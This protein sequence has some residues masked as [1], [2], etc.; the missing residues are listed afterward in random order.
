[1]FYLTPA[2]LL[3][4]AF[5]L[6]CF[7]GDPQYPLHPVRIIGKAVTTLKNLLFE[8]KLNGF[9]SGLL[10]TVIMIL[11]TLNIYII[12]RSLLEILHPLAP[13]PLD[14]FLIYSSIALKD[15]VKHAM[16]IAESLDKNNLQEARANVDKI[17]GRD[18]SNLDKDN[19]ARAAVESVAENYVDGFFAP[20]FWF[21]A[22][23][24]LYRYTWLSPAVTGVMAILIY[25][26]INTMDAMIGHKNEEYR[27]FGTFA[28]RFDDV[29]N[30]IPARLSL[31]VLTPA[32]FICRLNVKQAVRT[33]FRDR[34]KHES[35]NSAHAESF[36]AG[37]LNLK[38]GGPTQYPYGTVEKPWLGDGTPDATPDQIRTACKLITLAGWIS[39]VICLIILS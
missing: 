15:M 14:I 17:V 22:A 35:P 23:T 2:T 34:L 10:L 18:C 11:V 5:S 31:I 4:L 6:D 33:F 36:V 16:P 9:F 8:M 27:R 26:V 38:L 20:L 1:M 39:V 19:V 12:L 32:A 3:I 29:L 24:F 30:F 7:L 21:T 13:I 28:A 25:R 37:A